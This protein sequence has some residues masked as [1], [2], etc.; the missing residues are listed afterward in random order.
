MPT[1]EDET[2]ARLLWLDIA[3][4]L[5]L[6]GGKP[7]WPSNTLGGILLLEKHGLAR[8]SSAGWRRTSIHSLVFSTGLELGYANLSP[9]LGCPI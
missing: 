9:F 6:V 8:T 1:S 2:V 3:K 4:H 5:P 7:E